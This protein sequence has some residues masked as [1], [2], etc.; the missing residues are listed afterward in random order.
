MSL[1]LG[2]GFVVGGIFIGMEMR[3][4][5]VKEPSSGA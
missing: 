3:L 1:V 5:S 2:D 4:L